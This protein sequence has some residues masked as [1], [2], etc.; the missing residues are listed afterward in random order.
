MSRLKSVPYQLDPLLLLFVHLELK[1]MSVDKI[2][3]TEIEK[4]L[5]GE[6]TQTG[7]PKH[8][9]FKVF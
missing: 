1:H 4:Q 5:V 2:F 6:S 8:F 3:E 9:L 7:I